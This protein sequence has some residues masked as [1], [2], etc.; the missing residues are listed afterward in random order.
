[1]LHLILGDPVLV[2][3]ID[4]DT[5]G[6]LLP[7][8]NAEEFRPFT[9]KVPEFQFWYGLVRAIFIAWFMTMLP[10]FNIPVFW[11]VLVLYFLALMALTLKDRI[12][13]MIKHRYIPCSWG[14]RKYK[15][16]GGPA[17]TSASEVLFKGSSTQVA[18]PR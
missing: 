18:P 2:L 3:Q 8:S 13:H 7:T 12:L 14:K 17:S 11:P 6:P 16:K 1:M 4:P 10:F 9:R 15:G 5:Q